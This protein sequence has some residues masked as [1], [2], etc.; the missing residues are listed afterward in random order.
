MRDAVEQLPPLHA[1]YLDHQVE[2]PMGL[3][4]KS[5]K[6]EPVVPLPQLCY[7]IAYFILPHYVHS[8]Y[9]KLR[10]ICEQTPSSAGPYFDVTAC[11]LRTIEPDIETARGFRWHAGQF[12]DGRRYLTLEHPPPPP[13]PTCRPKR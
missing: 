6:R 12:S 4:S 10:D 2:S 5:Q 11:Q 8:D 9:D 13:V 7:D 3:F 1:N